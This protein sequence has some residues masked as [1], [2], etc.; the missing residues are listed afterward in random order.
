MESFL[1]VLPNL[2]FPSQVENFIGVQVP[3]SDSVS[4]VL[5]ETHASLLVLVVLALLEPV[6]IA[7]IP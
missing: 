5:N 4:G 1:F 3:N 7:G 6:C 2:L